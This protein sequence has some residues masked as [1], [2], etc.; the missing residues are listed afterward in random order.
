MAEG[1]G[2]TIAFGTSGFAAS[3]LEIGGMDV[4]RGFHETTHMGTTTAQTF[5]PNDLYDPGGVD[6]TFVV[7]GGNSVPI[8]QA[9]ETVTIDWGGDGNTWAFSGFLTD[10]SPQA[11]RGEQMIATARLKATGAITGI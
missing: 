4:S 7:V 5:S 1:G 9:A 11:S 10:Y 3:L 2:T 6:I 8:A